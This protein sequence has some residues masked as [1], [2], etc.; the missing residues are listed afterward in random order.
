VNNISI[1]VDQRFNDMEQNLVYLRQ[2][3]QGQIDQCMKKARPL[4]GWDPFNVGGFVSA[5]VWL[6]DITPIDDSNIRHYYIQFNNI[7]GNPGF[8]SD[9][10]PLPRTFGH[11]VYSLHPEYFNYSPGFPDVPYAV[12]ARGGTSY[13]LQ[14]DATTEQHCRL[15]YNAGPLGITGDMI[16]FLIVGNAVNQAEKSIDEMSVEELRKLTRELQMK[17]KQLEHK[18]DDNKEK[19]RQDMIEQMKRMKEFEFVQVPQPKKSSDMTQSTKT[20]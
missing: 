15:W 6:Y 9:W 1:N 14:M 11:F 5:Q 4:Q 12:S 10:V 7:S 13:T 3:L 19:L 20:K 17:T 8:S 18:K 16:G 2:Q